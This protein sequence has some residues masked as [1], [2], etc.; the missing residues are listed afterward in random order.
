MTLSDCCVTPISLENFPLSKDIVSYEDEFWGNILNNSL[1]FSATTNGA[2]D[3]PLGMLYFHDGKDYYTY[4][5]V[6]DD[7]DDTNDQV[8]I[9]SDKYIEQFEP[10]S[11]NSIKTFLPD[12]TIT[13]SRQSTS[14]KGSYTTN[15]K[16]R[17]RR[18]SSNTPAI[19]KKKRITP[20]RNPVSLFL[21]KQKRHRCPK[22]AS[23]HGHNSVRFGIFTGKYDNRHRLCPIKKS[24]PSKSSCHIQKCVCQFSALCHSP[25]RNELQL[26]DL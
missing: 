24:N 21:I 8:N 6:M 13:S 11:F 16:T 20:S 18:D 19:K 15:R 14:I 9:L 26:D 22:R 23:D 7:H 25:L 10:K 17:L 5:H 3:E 12:S 2:S 1:E 4:M